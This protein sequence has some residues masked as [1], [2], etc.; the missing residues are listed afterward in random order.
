M[1]FSTIEEVLDDVKNGKMIILVDDEDRENE[2]DAFVIGEKATPDVINFMV[3]HCRGLVCAPLS[4][5]RI[6][7]LHLNPMVDRSTDPRGTAFTVSVDG[8][9]TTTG[10]SAYERASTIKTLIDPE[11]Q[12]DDLTR[13]GHIFP[14]RAREGGV[15]VRA[16]H[17]EGAVDLAR[18]VGANPSGVI[19]EILKDDGTMARVP[20]LMQFA[21]K[22]GLKI[23]TI[24]D[25]I[26]YRRQHETLIEKV[27]EVKLPTDFGDFR[28]VGYHSMLDQQD[29]IALIK[30]DIHDGAPV[31]TRVHSECLTGDVF[32]SHRCDCGEQ[33][34]AAL[35]QIEKEGRGVLLYMRQ[36]GRGIGLLNKL[37]AYKLQEEGK[38]TV[39]ANLSLGFPADL[40]DYGVGAQILE[41]LGINKV[42]LMTNNPRKIVGLEGFGLEV[43]E[44]VP[45]EI[46][47][48]PENENYLSTKKHKMGHYLSEVK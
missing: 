11:S 4:G 25:L 23:T 29:H 21:E 31:L 13:P 3:T 20:D 37:K 9:D 39:E 15:L 6:D 27:A 43:A 35:R 14:L 38:D 2:G 26:R 48:K 28:A 16:G 33:L 7:A 42:R 17:T 45:M 24:Q 8:K 30:G 12:S 40:R 5:E 46:H 41:D 18:L 32:H 22:H 34:E 44:R 19:C 47:P 1:K 10:I 36:E